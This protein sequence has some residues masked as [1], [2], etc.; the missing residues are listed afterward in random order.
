MQYNYT[1]VQ[2]KASLLKHV[3][4]LH[5]EDVEIQGINCQCNIKCCLKPTAQSL[6]LQ[7]DTSNISNLMRKTLSA[8]T[9]IVYG[10]FTNYNERKLKN[11]NF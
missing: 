11:K 6:M 4:N 7:S 3:E 1:V 2:H 10:Y 8:F 5:E 9:K